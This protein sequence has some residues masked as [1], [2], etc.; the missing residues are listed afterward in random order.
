MSYLIPEKLETERLVLRPF[1]NEDW[2][3]MHVLYSDEACIAFT[4]GRVLTEGESWRTVASIAGH[5]L[6]R[7]YGPYA[8]EEKLS[9]TVL[10]TV[11]LWYPSDWPGLEIKW[12]LARR[13]WGRGFAS[14]AA[15]AVR[16]M[17]TE[18]LPQ[19]PLI[20]FIHSENAASIRV[21]LAVGAK[22][23]KE[24][25]F[26]NGKWHIYQHQGVIHQ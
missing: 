17:A 16:T 13:Y 26:R 25:D 20:S 19:T 1:N 8:V 12:A 18:F 23:E 11:G 21:A 6:L 15:R 3:A 4:M 24:I 9:G 5:W 7:G 10:G 2:Q 14:E 22:F